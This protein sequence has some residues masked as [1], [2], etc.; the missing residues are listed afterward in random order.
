[1][2]V[3]NDDSLAVAGASNSDR[4]FGLSSAYRRL[5]HVKKQKLI[6]EQDVVAYI[7]VFVVCY[8]VVIYTVPGGKVKCKSVK[9]WRELWPA[10]TS[11]GDTGLGGTSLRFA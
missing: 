6:S 10:A 7:I 4:N 8:L 3:L 2:S 1:M 5:Y 9:K 11:N